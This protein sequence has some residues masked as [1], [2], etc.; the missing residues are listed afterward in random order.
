M[1]VTKE[2]LQD[3]LSY[4]PR[5]LRAERAAAYLGLDISTFLDLVKDGALPKPVR[6]RSMVM[7]DRYDL[8]AA[9][10]ALKQRSEHKRRNPFEAKFGAYDNEDTT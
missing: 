6:V 8:D 5:V 1:R 2:K 9:F 4:P 10:D 7:W 3:R